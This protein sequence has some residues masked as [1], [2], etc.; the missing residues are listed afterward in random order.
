T[1]AV[2]GS[3]GGSRARIAR[4]D[5]LM[6]KLRAAT[7]DLA[8]TVPVPFYKTDAGRRYYA[9]RR[10][11]Q[12]ARWN[13]AGVCLE[14]GKPRKPPTSRCALCLVGNVSRVDRAVCKKRMAKAALNVRA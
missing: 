6:E 9:K 7:A 5:S 8:W 12:R 14:C 11:R 13:A 3:L 1:R 2:V 4:D 10:A